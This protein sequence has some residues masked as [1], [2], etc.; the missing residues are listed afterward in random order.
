MTK[1]VNSELSGFVPL[2]LYICLYY[3]WSTGVKALSINLE[4]SAY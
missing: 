3:Q 4:E 2:H 1:T